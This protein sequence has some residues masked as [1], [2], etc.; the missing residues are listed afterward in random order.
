MK[1]LII[2]SI[3]SLVVFCG[4][5]VALSSCEYQQIA[6]AEYPEQLIYMPAA[7]RGIFT[8]DDVTKPT[9]AVPTPGE[10]YKYVVDLP[11]GRFNVPLSVYRSGIDNT[12]AVNVTIAVNTDTITSL[13]AA[14]RLPANTTVLTPSQYTL[15]NSVVVEDGKEIAMF[16]LSVDLELLRTNYPV[17]VY[18]IG[19]GVSSTDRAV[20]PKLATTIVVL[21]SKMI[22]PTANFTS[23]AD[24]NN[25]KI[26][27]FNS[28]TTLYGV[29]FTWN[30]G[31]G[32][33]A[34]TGNANFRPAHTYAAAGTYDV[35]LA[36]LGATGDVDKSIITKQVV[37]N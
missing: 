3:K 28:A 32:T 37:V 16:T 8:I 12:G 19:V 14:A 4:V 9:L 23:S 5:L 18:A 36:V 21:H 31:D 34:V 35:T 30:F 7:Y 20:N 22:K 11:G 13:V 17:E 26:I 29:T 15:T 10:P 2:R 27:N 24:A 25:I 6:D 33:E 1:S